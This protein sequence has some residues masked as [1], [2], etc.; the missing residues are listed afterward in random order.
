[1]RELKINEILENNDILNNDFNI[2][3]KIFY[4]EKVLLLAK[5]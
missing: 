1:L 4:D 5:N 2:I 3:Y